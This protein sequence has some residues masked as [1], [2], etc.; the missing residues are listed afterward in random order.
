MKILPIRPL[1]LVAVILSVLPS[2]GFAQQTQFSSNYAA[3]S[4]ICTNGDGGAE[5][6]SAC[7]Q[8]LQ[9]I[10]SEIRLQTD[11]AQY[12]LEIAAVA[13]ALVN[14]YIGIASPSSQIL[15]LIADALNEIAQSAVDPNQAEQIIAIAVRVRSGSDLSGG[16]ERLLASPN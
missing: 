4:E 10:L 14:S 16:I 2:I 5:N 6:R 7:L 15:S 12:D 3:T 8:S 1:A 11:G 13:L 9:S